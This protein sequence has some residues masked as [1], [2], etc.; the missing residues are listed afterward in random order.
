MKGYVE[1]LEK[2]TEHLAQSQTMIEG[3][4]AHELRRSTLGDSGN[5][6][7]AGLLSRPRDLK[8]GAYR[9]R[10][11]LRT[12]RK[13]DGRIGPSERRRQAGG[14]LFSSLTGLAGFCGGGACAAAGG[15]AWAAGRGGGGAA[16]VAGGG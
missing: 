9:Q 15:G 5:P 1:D 12:V 3:T 10:F 8:S 11:A 6:G 4:L 13:A 14:C 7:T 2:L 16:R